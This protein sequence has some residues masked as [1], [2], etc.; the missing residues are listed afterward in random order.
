MTPWFMLLTALLRPDCKF[1]SGDQI[2]GADLAGAVP[3]FAAMPRD[4]VI[5][6]SPAPGLRRTFQFAELKRI[7]ARY[8][9]SVPADAR[10][11]F[12][13]KVRPLVE[14]DVRAAIVESLGVPQARIDVLAMSN[15]PVPEGKLVFPRSGVAAATNTGP[16]T[17]VTWRGYVSY[18]SSRRFEIWARVTMSASMPRVV[19]VENLLPGK[20]VQ[21]GQ[22]QIEVEDEFPL[23]N[24]TVTR[25]EDVVG[26]MPRIMLRAGARVLRANLVEAFQVEK[27]Q[28]VEVKVI[29]GAAHLELEAIAEA[30]GRQGEVISLRNPRSE[31]TFRGQID[32]KGRAVVVV[33]AG[34][35]LAGAQ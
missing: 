31:K 21:P 32:G 16:S 29:S 25:L 1:V 13:W 11:C 34:S 3:A 35:L 24:D 27:G 14:E 2:F 17:P 15:T 9:I 6:Y 28:T 18:N 33:G 5:G 30:S 22:V 26:R 19:A 23:R 12:D 4:T 8:S 10:A 7:G 20:P